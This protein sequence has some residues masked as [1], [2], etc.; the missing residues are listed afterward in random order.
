MTEASSA[1]SHLSVVMTTAHADVTQTAA[2]E[3]T[4]MSPSSFHVE[5][6]FKCAIIIIGI[7]GT[8]AN[9]LVLYALVASK[10]HKKHVLLVNQNVLDLA[11]CL[12]VVTI[13]ALKVSNINLSGLR[14][15]WLC[16]MLLSENL[17]WFAIDGSIIN[18]AVITIERYLKVVYAVWSK[19]KL[20]KWMIYLSMAL[21]WI[22]A[23]I[24]N[25]ALTFTTSAVI[26]GVCHGV[27][28]WEY[29]VAKAVHGVWHFLSFYA[30][31]LFIFIF[32]YMRILAKIRR[33]ASVMAGHS[34]ASTAQSAAQAQANQ[35]QSNVVKTMI[36]VCA[37]FAIAWLPEN[38]YYL[39]VDVGANLTFREPGYYA[40]VFVS[41]LYICMNPFIYATKFDPVKRI[42][43]GLIPRRKD[44]QRADEV[45][46][47]PSVSGN[48]SVRSVQKCNQVRV[49]PK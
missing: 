12:F 22:T 35:I 2:G 18:L 19:A 44:D 25:M 7:V 26:D 40:V 21:S 9:A 48:I 15:Y 1:T 31:I 6:C 10:Q 33:Q 4:V 23:F 8:G 34:T 37:F 11:S 30:I 5:F 24:Y 47:V 16:M 27:V 43:F 39:L 45:Q 17:L 38:V 32:C 36:P 41:F 14:G 13:Y 42:L 3:N 28:V 46:M 20:R 49:A 29:H